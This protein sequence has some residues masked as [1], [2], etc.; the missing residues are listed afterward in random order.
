MLKLYIV[1]TPSFTIYS[2]YFVAKYHE[3]GFNDLQFSEK[4]N[5]LKSFFIFCDTLVFV[6]QIDEK[7]YQ[8]VFNFL[9]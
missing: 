1:E 8:N 5:F 4:N 6:F 3:L 9:E 7:I 2:N